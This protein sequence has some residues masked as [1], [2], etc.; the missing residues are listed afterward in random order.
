MFCALAVRMALLL[1]Q[2]GDRPDM[3]KPLASYISYSLHLFP[4]LATAMNLSRHT[5][6]CALL[7]V[8][9]GSETGSDVQSEGMSTLPEARSSLEPAAQPPPALSSMRP[10][11]LSLKRPAQLTNL[12]RLS[13]VLG[14]PDVAAPSPLAV[15]PGTPM[16]LLFQAI[17][18][19]ARYGGPAAA[20]S[21]SDDDLVGCD[22][23]F[24]RSD[25]LDST[26]D[27]VQL[28]AGAL[29]VA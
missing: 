20:S 3:L 25:C 24:D 21:S 4:S 18:A 5:A 10:S 2:R 9:Q 13:H 17:P 12:S 16:D 11:N 15:H 22:E 27:D 19:N 1:M 29:D 28:S 23:E 7:A 26:D 8:T 14:S 6:L